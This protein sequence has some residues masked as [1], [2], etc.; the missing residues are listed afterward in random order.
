VVH[1]RDSNVVTRRVTRRKSGPG[2]LA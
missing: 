2:D 1:D